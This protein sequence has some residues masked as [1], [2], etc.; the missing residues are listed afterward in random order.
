VSDHYKPDIWRLQSQF[1]IQGLTKA[2]HD[3]DPGIRKRAAAALRAMGAKESVPALRLALLNETDPEARASMVAALDAMTDSAEEEA[4][5]RQLPPEQIKVHKL[6]TQLKSKDQ[7]EVIV[8]A[9]ELGNLGD[10][11][12]VEPLVFL[13]ND[14]R[15][16]MQIR[17]AVAEALLKLE[18]APVEVALLANLRSP[19]WE[20]RRKAAAILGHLKAS[21]AVPPLEK[22]LRDAHPIVRKTAQAALK[23][24]GTP[25]ARKALVRDRQMATGPLSNVPRSAGPNDATLPSP[26]Q[27]GLLRRTMKPGQTGKLSAPPPQGLL[28]RATQEESSVTP[29][30]PAPAA[31]NTASTQPLDPKVVEEIEKRMKQHTTSEEMKAVQPTEP[32]PDTTS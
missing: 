19:D 13:F 8:A 25:E 9:R 18:S 7:D 32:P 26:P 5:M 4:E 3:K 6:I 15:G 2:L 11:I 28:K 20:I 30:K 10:K 1:D 16:S 22:M 24:I 17:L 23:N 21:W 14:V 27:G 31:I 29:E 12:A